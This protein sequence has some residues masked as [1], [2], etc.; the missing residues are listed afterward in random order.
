[1]IDFNFYLKT[2]KNEKCPDSAS[3]C[4]K[5]PAAETSTNK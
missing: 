4:S 3:A 5:E 2:K 1:L